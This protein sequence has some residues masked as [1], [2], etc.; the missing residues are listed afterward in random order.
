MKRCF[1]KVVNAF[2]QLVHGMSIVEKIG[3]V[4]GTIV[5]I[6]FAIC[7]YVFTDTV[8]ATAMDYEPLEKQMYAI[9]QNPNLLLKTDC[10]ININNDI[11]TV[12]L[13]NAECGLNVE[14]GK[15][16]E[17]LS[18]SNYDKG[19]YWLGT[20]IWAISIGVAIFVLVNYS[21]IIMEDIYWENKLAP[22]C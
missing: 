18:T 14:Y 17:I 20:L 16:F 22:I 1:T 8:P 3:F 4:I 13:S 2:I 6:A 11:I 9:Q 15:N 21:V 5:A 10:N 12:E 19:S 7:F